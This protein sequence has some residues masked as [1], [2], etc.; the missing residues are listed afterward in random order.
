MRFFTYM[1]IGFLVILLGTSLSVTRA[2]A[3]NYQNNTIWQTEDLYWRDHYISRPYYRN[4]TDYSYYAPAYRYGFDMYNQYKG[5]AYEKLNESALREN[6][7]ANHR[8][9]GLSWQ[10]ARGPA[11]D[12]YNRMYERQN[13]SENATGNPKFM[14]MASD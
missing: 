3:D 12:A 5:K 6:W 2:A 13:L 9:T 8:D 10:D 4:E 14:E 1:G 11:Q 7:N